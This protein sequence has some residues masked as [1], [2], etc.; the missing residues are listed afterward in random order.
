PQDAQEQAVI[1]AVR[2]L[3]LSDDDDEGEDEAKAELDDE[4]DGEAAV[5]GATL[6]PAGLATLSVLERQVTELK[7]ENQKIRSRAAQ[8]KVEL[9][10]KRSIELGCPIEDDVRKEA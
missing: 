6:D 9:A 2:A 1:D 8:E 7:A 3:C 4:A 5:P 10:R